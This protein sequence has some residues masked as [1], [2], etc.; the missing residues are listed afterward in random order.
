M[1]RFINH[2]W[3]INAIPHQC[4]VAITQ[5]GQVVALQLLADHLARLR[6]RHAHAVVQD[7]DGGRQGGRQD[8][9]ELALVEQ[10]FTWTKGED[11]AEA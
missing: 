8:A 3:F 1:S 11:A 4:P 7:V 2:G 10:V 9:T 6:Q 5:L